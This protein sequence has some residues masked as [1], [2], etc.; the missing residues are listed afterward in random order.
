MPNGQ[1]R[2]AATVTVFCRLRR[3]AIKARRAG[4]R[5]Q[6]ME[7]AWVLALLMIEFR[8]RVLAI[9]LFSCRDIVCALWYD[10]DVMAW[11]CAANMAVWGELT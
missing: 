11:K 5:D 6:G 8:N 3:R 7:I 9:V 2:L 1:A 10:G 4:P